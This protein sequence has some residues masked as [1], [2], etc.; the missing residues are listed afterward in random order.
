MCILALM[1]VKIEIRDTEHDE[2][3]PRVDIRIN[4]PAPAMDE[5]TKMSVMVAWFM[6]YAAEKILNNAPVRRTIYDI[7]I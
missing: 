7:K 3:G 1:T 6:V 5:E 4:Q 2:F